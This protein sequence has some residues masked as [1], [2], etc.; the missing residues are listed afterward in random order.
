MTT[1]TSDLR[2]QALLEI[3]ADNRWSIDRLVSEIGTDRETFQRWLNSD[4]FETNE[5]LRRRAF[6][7][8]RVTT[9]L[10][11]YQAPVPVPRLRSQTIKQKR[12]KM[13][14]EPSDASNINPAPNTSPELAGEAL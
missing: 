11:T 8:D 5:Q 6:M 10:D 14:S 1:T 3:R 12:G 13:G 9:F 4:Y 2:R 7:L